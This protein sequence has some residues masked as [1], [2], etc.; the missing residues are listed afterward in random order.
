VEDPISTHRMRIE[1]HKRNDHA[2]G[3]FARFESQASRGYH[4]ARILI[5]YR[6]PETT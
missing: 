5:L 1:L 3:E 6:S 2:E 4:S